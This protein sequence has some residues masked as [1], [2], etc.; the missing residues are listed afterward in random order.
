MKSIVRLT[1]LVGALAL[2]MGCEWSSGGDESSFNTRFNFLNWNGIYRGN[3]GAPVISD[4]SAVPGEDITVA[5]EGIATGNG[6]NTLFSGALAQRA[7]LPGTLTITA[8]AYTF[9][10][11]N[12]D[13]IL[14]GTPSGAGTIVYAT[15][16][17]TLD[18]FGAAPAAGEP[19]TASYVYEVAGNAAGPGNTGG[20]IESIF[21]IHDGEVLT[22]K[23]NLG[24]VY[25]GR[26]GR[27]GPSS[28]ELLTIN[29]N[30]PSADVRIPVDIIAQ[31]NVQGINSAG[32]EVT[33][34][35]VFRARVGSG[36]ATLTDRVM[37]GTYTERDGQIGNVSGNS[38]PV[39]IDLGGEQNLGG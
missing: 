37:E 19:I 38:P 9:N 13:G 3:N 26:L 20:R 16:A 17:W 23:D 12:R 31:F 27:I 34:A 18:F 30:D 39:G 22:F 25:M 15:G 5:G 32:K 2:V 1:S 35:G 14:D 6:A 29:S 4:F 8:G 33:I 24:A 36:G 10:D 7:I 21:V 28:G 11:P